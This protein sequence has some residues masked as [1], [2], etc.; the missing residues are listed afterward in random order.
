MMDQKDIIKAPSD[1]MFFTWLYKLISDKHCTYNEKNNRILD[2]DDYVSNW[3]IIGRDNE[4][5][6]GFLGIPRGLLPWFSQIKFKQATVSFK[7]GRLYLSCGDEDEEGITISLKIRRERLK[8]LWRDDLKEDAEF[9]LEFRIFAPKA[10]GT[11]SIS[12]NVIYRMK[13]INTNDLSRV[14]RPSEEGEDL[15]MVYAEDIKARYEQMYAN[16]Y[17]GEGEDGE[18]DE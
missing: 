1:I 5:L 4:T 14:V 13:M 16:Q 11:L 10:D 17:F 2:L 12:D 6:N 15:E 18:D 9:A 3:F 8:L 7:E